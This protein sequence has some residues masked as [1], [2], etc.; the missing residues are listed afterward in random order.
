MPAVTLSGPTTAERVRS[1]CVRAG[2]A[3]LAADGAS[4]VDARVHHLLPDGAFAMTIAEDCAMAIAAEESATGVAAVLELTDYAPL[5]L[6]EPVRSLVWVRGRVRG[7]DAVSVRR[8]LDVIAAEHPNPAL[9]EVG[10][11]H[12]LLLL[13][14]E[15]VVVADS[16]G[17]E[18]VRLGALLAAQPDPFCDL[19]SA[20]V[21]HLEADHPEVM[22]RLACKLPA[23]LRKGRVRP[24]GLDRYGIRLRIEGPTGDHDVRLPFSA[25]VNDATG[26]GRAI[27]AL[28]G[29]PFANGLRARPSGGG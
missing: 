1:A 25:P 16:G 11:T 8:L 27:R 17:A 21:R 7:V 15:S 20:W 18:S 13:V 19:E 10:S 23:A 22:A 12:V 24:L 4:P 29:C 6:R 2:G 14:V 9:L 5:A 26:L 3:M 28:M